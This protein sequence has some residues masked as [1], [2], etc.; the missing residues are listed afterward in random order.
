VRV[1]SSADEVAA[2]RKNVR[3]GYST[4]A[5]GTYAA[6]YGFR[7]KAI[8]LF[9]RLDGIDVLLFVM[10]VQEY[11]VDS[12]AP[13]T[14]QVYIAYLDSVQYFRPRRLRT[15]VYQT[16]LASYMEYVRR[17]GF[18]G[19][20]IW[21]CPPLRSGSYIFTS[22]PVEQQV[23]TGQRLRAWYQQMLHVCHMHGTVCGQTTMYERYFGGMGDPSGNRRRPKLAAA[24]KVGGRKN[25][26][27]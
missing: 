4:A 1:V 25:V 12:P 20:H 8:F 19:A 10:Y 21:A 2:V 11:G 13:N 26:G 9:Q 24:K 27:R 18:T 6:E 23:P 22:R 15:T 3:G 14:R 16:L 7:S 5:A 17:R